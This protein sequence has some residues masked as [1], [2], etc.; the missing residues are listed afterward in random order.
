MWQPNGINFHFGLISSF[1][2]TV[3]WSALPAAAFHSVQLA[4][5]ISHHR[6][7]REFTLIPHLSPPFFFFYYSNFWSWA[8]T[9]GLGVS[10]LVRWHVHYNVTK[11][12]GG[13]NLRV[14]TVN[15]ISDLRP[16]CLLPHVVPLGVLPIVL[17]V[18]LVL[19]VCGTIQRQ[20]RVSHLSPEPFSCR[21]ICTIRLVNVSKENQIIITC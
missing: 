14:Q 1:R 16:P 10:S 18:Q 11:I 17:L 7:P 4:P 3:L 21:S 2:T 15:E 12:K 13:K 19:P 20:L 5:K 8:L 6:H 9:K